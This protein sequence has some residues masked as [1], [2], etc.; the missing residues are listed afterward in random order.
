MRYLA[1][2]LGAAAGDVA[3]VFAV[4]AHVDGAEVDH[5]VAVAGEGRGLERGQNI[6]QRFAE[7][8]GAAAE[9]QD[10]D[11]LPV[12]QQALVSHTSREK[13]VAAVWQKEVLGG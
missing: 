2:D 1:S 5:H 7:T 8:W 13:L 11:V 6:K 9:D 3:M 12:P 4:G 10:V